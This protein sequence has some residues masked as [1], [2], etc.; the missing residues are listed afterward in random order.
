MKVMVAQFGSQTQEYGSSILHNVEALLRGNGFEVQP[1]KLPPMDDANPLM[2]VTSWRLLPV[3]SMA[4]SL[5]CLDARSAVLQHPKKYL[6]L[7]DDA[8]DSVRVGDQHE[9]LANV[10]A[11]GIREC[12]RVFVSAPA[13]NRLDQVRRG[14]VTELN[15]PVPQPAGSLGKATSKAYAPLLTALRA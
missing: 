15:P 6:W 1:L 9:Y 3:A 13:E 12:Q 5:L 4:D 11:A 14:G 7:L 2:S 10:L 8:D